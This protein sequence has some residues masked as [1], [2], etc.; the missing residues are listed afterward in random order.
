MLG[1]PIAAIMWSAFRPPS[2]LLMGPVHIGA[3]LFNRQNAS[4]SRAFGGLFISS[5]Y[6]VR[7]EL[8]AALGVVFLGFR[9]WGR[10]R[11]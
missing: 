6:L 9:F 10:P 4:Q 5:R 8:A 7:L 2:W 3:M 1:L 11:F